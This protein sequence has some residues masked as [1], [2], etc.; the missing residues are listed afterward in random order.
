LPELLTQLSSFTVFLAIAAVGF[1]FLLISLLFGEVFGHGDVSL[2]HDVDHD[3]GHGGPSFFSPRIISVFVTAFGGFGA[4]GVHY[5]LSVLGASGL[6]F[7]SGIFFASIIYLFARF[8][9]S[10]QA[11]TVVREADMVGQDVRVVVAIPARGVGQVRCRVGDEL[12]DKIAR[13][14]DGQPIDENEVVRVE[15]TLGEVVVVRRAVAS[16]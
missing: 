3:L 15:Q 11:T 4:V 8:L 13:S 1:L 16:Q 12:I 2:D 14:G 5:G 10:Q 6:G 9:F 7:V